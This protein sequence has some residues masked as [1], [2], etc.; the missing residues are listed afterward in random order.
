LW[1]AGF[2]LV[3]WH[4]QQPA[5]RADCVSAV[6]SA[7]APSSAELAR[8]RES[9]HS[10]LGDADAG[11]WPQA[12]L[13]FEEAYRRSGNPVALLNLAR[14]LHE[15]G[16]AADARSCVI[17]LRTR[18]AHQLDG[19]ALAKANELYTSVTAVIV[20]RAAPQH[21]G[22]LVDGASQAVGAHGPNQDVRRFELDP[23]LHRIEVRESGRL[24]FQ[25]QGVAAAAQ[26][27]ELDY[28]APP[29]AAAPSA[30]SDSTH[31]ASAAAAAAKSASRHGERRDGAP[32]Y[33]NPWLWTGIAAALAGTAVALALT[34]HDRDAE[35]YGGSSGKVFPGP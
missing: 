6:R 21:A 7:A 17:A 3:I 30:T 23:G 16:R 31:Q 4:G 14:A 34:L 1:L 11:R 25:W 32:L 15:S 18:H 9:F 27:Q 29:L 26:T 2:L 10:G 5:V 20:L 19:E 33:K 22:V 35:P 28:R 24:P 8:A 12:V 13:A